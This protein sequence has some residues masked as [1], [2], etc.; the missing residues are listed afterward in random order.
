MAYE[1]GADPKARA[2]VVKELT[3]E[4][5]KG[6][7]GLFDSDRYRD[8]LIAMARFYR[9]SSRNC[10]LILMQRPSASLVASFSSW[11]HD[12]GRHVRKG[13]RG[14]RILAPSNRKT[15]VLEPVK[16]QLGELALDTDGQVRTEFVERRWTAFVPV[17]VFDVSQTEG[18]PIP[19]L[20]SELDRPIVGFRE[21]RDKLEALSPVPVRFAEVP[22]G[23]GNGWYSP[24]RREIVVKAGMGDAQTIKTLAHE[25]A[26]A[27][28]HGP[29]SEEIPDAN[30]RE[31]QAES[32]AFV[33]CQRLR[34]DT[35]GYSFGYVA[36]WSSGREAKELLASLDTIRSASCSLIE[37]LEGAVT[38]GPDSLG[39]VDRTERRHLHASVRGDC[40]QASGAT[41]I[42]RSASR[43][44]S[45][46]VER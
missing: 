46:S 5:E 35:S 24:S 45:P 1:K 29:M 40:S 3:E 20:V 28:L 4:L 6:V 41:S 15:S 10:L 26:H 44:T 34:I 7:Q 23:T 21:L 8:Y 30:T 12:F 19:T 14:I 9:Y 37:R 39:H 17:S 25:I 16:N 32:V 43:E 13:E 36:S 2:R 11:Q 31:V 33:V 22:D 27:T 18:D 42:G 38:H